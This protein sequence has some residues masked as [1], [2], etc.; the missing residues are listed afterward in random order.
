MNTTSYYTLLGDA[1]TA[2]GVYEKEVDS[3]DGFPEAVHYNIERNIEIN[4][5]LTAALFNHRY[6]YQDHSHG[7]HNP[8]YAEALLRN[9]LDAVNNLD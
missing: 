4:G 2:Y 9:S 3:V 7:M 6:L 5:T 8:W 1:L